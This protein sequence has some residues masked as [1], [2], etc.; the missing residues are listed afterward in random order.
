MEIL[1]SST[2]R[3]HTKHHWEA[4]QLPQHCICSLLKEAASAGL[5]YHSV[6]DA[7]GERTFPFCVLGE[8]SRSCWSWIPRTTHDPTTPTCGGHYPLSQSLIVGLSAAL[9]ALDSDRAG[10]DF[11]PSS[12]REPHREPHKEPQLH[13]WAGKHVRR[14]KHM[15]SSLSSAAVAVSELR[16][17]H[18]CPSTEAV[19]PG[20]I[21]S[22]LPN[23]PKA[24][25]TT[26]SQPTSCRSGERNTQEGTIDTSL[27]TCR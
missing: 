20:R 5:Q 27:S 23:S 18:P 16:L 21:T 7:N 2:P 9:R 25:P 11:F 10:S 19:V 3:S 17:S 6:V 1:H 15:T 22:S 8:R 26:L 24:Q 4:L 13:C 14:R 12:V